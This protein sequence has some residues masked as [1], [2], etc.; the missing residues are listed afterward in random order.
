V[1][2]GVIEQ[3]DRAGYRVHAHL[4]DYARRRR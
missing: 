4:D 2:G 3:F 1:H